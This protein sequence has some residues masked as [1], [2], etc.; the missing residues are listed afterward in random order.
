MII[1]EYIVIAFMGGLV[2]A[3]I[4]AK[5]PKD[6]EKWDIM[7]V[8]LL[9]PI[10]G[11]LYFTMVTEWNAPDKVIT[12]FFAYAFIDIIDRLARRIIYRF[13]RVV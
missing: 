2:R 13:T 5:T 12:F 8:V 11:Y 10:A 1:L 9:S 7:K 4:S 3:I 6:I